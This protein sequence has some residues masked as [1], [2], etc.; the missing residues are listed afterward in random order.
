MKLTFNRI[1]AERAVTETIQVKGNI[2]FYRLSDLMP[3]NL[4]DHLHLRSR[5]H[6]LCSNGASHAMHGP[7]ITFGVLNPRF[8]KALPKNCKSQYKFRGGEG[9]QGPIY[10][11]HLLNQAKKILM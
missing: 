4:R 1:Q 3:E 7:S 2:T 11:T 9:P 5:G 8:S 6:H 10:P